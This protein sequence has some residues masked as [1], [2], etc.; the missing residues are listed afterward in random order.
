MQIS[1]LPSFK[2]P[3]IV[4]AAATSLTAIKGAIFAIRTFNDSG[5]TIAANRSSASSSNLEFPSKASQRVLERAI[6]APAPSLPIFLYNSGN[7]SNPKRFRL[8][9]LVSRYYAAQGSPSVVRLR[10]KTWPARENLQ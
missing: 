7:K 10:S 2:A 3:I 5:S 6:P 1:Q 9:S 8:F 4:Y